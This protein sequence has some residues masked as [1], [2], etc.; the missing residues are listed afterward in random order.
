MRALNNDN[1][2]LLLG[3][4]SN[5]RM[6]LRFK[7]PPYVHFVPPSVNGSG[8]L[9]WL[10]STKSFHLLFIAKPLLSMTVLKCATLYTQ[11]YEFVLIK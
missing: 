9:P 2:L 7:P 8:S 1:S 10:K 3:Q 6:W 4:G 11:E 5:E